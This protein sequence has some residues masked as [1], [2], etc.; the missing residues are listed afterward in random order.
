MCMPDGDKA[1]KRAEQ[2]EAQRQSQISGNVQSINRAFAG[3]EPQYAQFTQ[4]LR[5]RLNTQFGQQRQAATRQ[6]KF[7][8][9]KS[10]LTGGSAAIDAGR[11]LTREGQEGALQVERTAQGA[12]ADLRAKDENARNQ[13]IALAQSGTN[14]GN[15]GQQTAQMLQAN[16]GSA[17]N[18]DL[19]N[20]L[21]DVFGGTAQAYRTAVDAKERRRGLDTA[22]L[23]ARA[24]TR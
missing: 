16:I 15:A 6:N 4:A 14:I 20:R 5:N 13:M 23:Y 19:T 24:F 17:Q 10:G 8:L 22:N 21:G 1:T 12:G 18:Q 2:A 3:R 7:A 11:R 9:A